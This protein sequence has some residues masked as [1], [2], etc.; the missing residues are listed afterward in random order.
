MQRQNENI[1]S[2]YECDSRSSVTQTC[3]AKCGKNMY[4]FFE[5]A[6]KQHDFP[7]RVDHAMLFQLKREI[8]AL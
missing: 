5:S 1:I 3:I 4:K 7:S 8:V 2:C 6:L